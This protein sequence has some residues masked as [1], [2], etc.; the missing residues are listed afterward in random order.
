MKS[1]KKIHII[2]ITILASIILSGFPL[3][4]IGTSASLASLGDD[5]SEDFEGPFFAEN[6]T[7]TGLW[8]LEDNATSS[9]PIWGSM[10]SLS[11]YMWYGSNGTGTYNTSVTNSGDLIS[12]TCDLSGFTGE[13]FLEFQ[14]W[15]ETEELSGLD[16]ASLNI[17]SDGGSTWY[18]LIS[19]VKDSTT[20]QNV[21]VD[22]TSYKSA[23]VLFKFSFD[24]VDKE[25]NNY[26]GW[27]IDDIKIKA[28]SA[29]DPGY[30][31]LWIYQDYE[32]VV[33]HLIWMDLDLDSYFSHSMYVNLSVIIETPS[34]VNTTIYENLSVFIDAYGS[35]YHSISY[36]FDKPGDYT[37]WF[38]LIDDI[39]E[40]WY[41]DCW[42]E[43]HDH[44]F[45]DI[46]VYQDNYAGIGET[47]SMDFEIDSFFNHSMTVEIEIRLKTPTGEINL[48]NKTLVYFDALGYWYMSIDYT[49]STA[50]RYEVEFVLIDDIDH[51]WYRHC[52]WEVY[53]GEYFALYLE[54][55]HNGF[56]G[57]LLWLDAYVDSYF[58]VG[59]IVTIDLAVI[60]PNE[61]LIQLYHNN[62][63]Y[64]A[65]YDYWFLYP[66]V[67]AEIP[68]HYL[69]QLIVTDSSGV[70]W[71]VDCWWDI[72]EYDEFY[73]WIE[74]DNFAKI[75]EDRWMKFKLDSTFDDMEEVSVEIYIETPLGLNETHF[76]N[77]SIK[78][79]AWGHWGFELPYKFT[80]NG[81]YTVYFIVTDEFGNEWV[82][83]CWWVIGDDVPQ[84]DPYI[85]IEGPDY[86]QVNETFTVKGIIY[87]GHLGLDVFAVKLVVDGVLIEV[88]N[89]SVPHLM[90]GSTEKVEFSLIFASDG[91][92]NVT[93]SVETDKGILSDD[94]KL[95]V[96]LP[97]NDT[98]TS[99]NG[100]TSETSDSKPE[101]SVEL[102][103]GFEG[104]FVFLCLIPITLTLRKKKR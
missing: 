24:T 50:G 36:I 97:S 77:D 75:N 41:A 8:H 44:E 83:L 39:E 27:M 49:F 80:M 25:Y 45:F 79:P 61:T 90:P 52:W 99:I 93:V 2:S 23:N 6:W 12:D 76:K 63:Y 65:P 11:H 20:W 31:D 7:T 3:I 89:I 67:Y 62:S 38:I 22:I 64:M 56:V 71:R 70:Q 102:S 32:T 14:S 47:K 37:V 10:P 101:P 103:P 78:I 34:G 86:V 100:T 60:L 98:T 17:S 15:L 40:E 73:L 81:N 94:Y 19:Q 26:R 16:V 4:P 95:S 42:W 54:Q 72:Q 53:E 96:K 46:Y 30:F 74:Q 91:E 69:V 13:V 29:R 88:R 58:S 1:R 85:E 92:F 87:A 18:L 51:H 21:T 104:L 5:L 35:W 28:G 9:Y 43:V 57:D 66:E 68:G 82:F 84:K 48:Y 33:G 59:Q 55:E